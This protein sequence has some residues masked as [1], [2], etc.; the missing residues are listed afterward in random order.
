MIYKVPSSFVNLLY[1]L[2]DGQ[3][4]PR[5]SKPAIPGVVAQK[6]PVWRRH[7]IAFIQL[8]QARAQ[9]WKVHFL[10]VS[11]SSFC[12]VTKSRPT[13]WD[14]MDYCT[15]SCPPLS[16]RVG[17]NS[18]SLHK[19]H[20]LIT[21]SFAF[22]CSQHQDYSETNKTLILKMASWMGGRPPLQ[23]NYIQHLRDKNF[24]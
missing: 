6:I 3:D 22:N 11:L 16:P 13:L 18:C 23:R 8:H 1:L 24:L 12:S 20:Y 5:P 21:S 4:D 17:P 7:I 9:C 19:W 2:K 10:L 15:P 14:S